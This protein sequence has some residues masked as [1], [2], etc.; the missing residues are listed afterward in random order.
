M[1]NTEL[2]EREKNVLRFIVQ[3]FILTASPVGS[4]NITRRYNLNFS[5][6]TV[7]NTMS[8]LE[9]SGFINHPHT[10]AGR[11]PTDKGYRFYVNSLM[12]SDEL[13]LPDKQA[14]SARLEPSLT[15]TT[16][17]LNMAARILSSITSQL[18]CVLYPRLDTGKL[19]RIQLVLL[20]STRLLIVM[21]IEG[22]Q[23]KTITLE[24]SAEVT[25]PQ[26]L[27]LQQ[28][29]NERLA[30]LTLAEIRI[31]FKERVKDYFTEQHP[32]LTLF[33]DSAEKIFT[34]LPT[35]STAILAGAGQLLKQPEFENSE[36]LQTVIQLIENKDII[37]HVLEKTTG[38]SG[39]NVNITIGSESEVSE[40]NDFSL[41]STEYQIGNLAG[42]LG[43]IGPKRMEYSK[44]VAIVDYISNQLTEVLTKQ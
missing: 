16:E 19:E 12:P 25:E 33:V 4:R 15:D 28:I 21:S 22:G 7:R 44:I 39:N 30:G 34:D 32:V 11:I 1:I 20:S 9:D 14:I 40:L 23:V 37:V 31:S 41:V 36:K 2:T 13:A 26:V 18:A 27:I 6:A 5:P 24:I 29:L 42:T 35:T 38:N 3:Q 17:I 8:D 10:S 43:V